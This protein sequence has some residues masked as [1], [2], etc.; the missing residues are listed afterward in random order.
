MRKFVLLVVLLAALA[1]LVACNQQPNPPAPQ[2]EAA[3]V[4]CPECPTC[5]EAPACPEVQ[6]CPEPE[7]CPEPVVAVVPFEEQ[8][9]GSPHNDAE[10]EAFV[11]WNEDD[12]A[13]I[14]EN[15]AKCHSTPG[16]IDFLGADGSDPNMVN[17]PAPI[18]STVECEAC[19]NDVTIHKTS[20]VFPS[21]IEIT[22]LGDESRCMECHQGRES[23]TSVDASI[24]AAGL[25]DE[26][27][28]VNADLGF[29]NIHYYAAAATQY[30]TLAKGG[31]EYDGLTYDAK[32]HHVDGFNTCN[33]CHDP[34]TLELNLEQCQ[35]CH[36]DVASPED[37]KAVRLEGSEADY[38]GDG[39]VEE[40]VM[41]EI[42]GLQEPLYQAIRAYASEVAGAPIVYDAAAHPYFFADGNDN[43]AVDEGEERYATWTPRL[44]RAAYNFQVSNKDP[45]EF[46]HNGKYIIQLLYDS[47]ADLN[48]SIAEPVDMTT[49][50]RIDP[51]HFAG[52][53][54]AFRHWDADGAVPGDCAKCHSGDG[55][56]QF[57]AE[58]TNTSQPP[59]NGFKCTTCHTNYE[60]YARIQIETVTFP[61]GAELTMADLDSNLCISCHQGRAW[62]GTIDAATG[63]LAEDTVP[64]NALRFT[65][66]HYFAAGATL[67]G[68][69]AKGAY[70]YPDLT[71]LGKFNH[72][73]GF[74]NCT[75]C[76][77]T[78]EL[79]LKTETCFT[80]H[81]GLETPQ[82]IRGPNSTADYDGDGDVTEGLANEIATYGEK[83]YAAMQ[84][85]ATE[86][87]G[88]AI[89]YDG[90][91]YPYFFED[92]DG[93]GEL[94]GDE[95]GYTAW[96]PRLLKAAYNYQYLQK[97][98]GAFAHNGKY[99]IQFLYDNLASLGEQVEVDMAGMI[100]PETP[101]AE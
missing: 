88:K 60:D 100:R 9:A 43:G 2:P 95:A 97:D 47:I 94:N 67:F 21:G 98:P 40:G 20:V 8:W 101:P 56:P 31:Y 90:H 12:P 42:L 93:N 58:G 13:Q 74:Q 57:V 73:P 11:H 14:P 38:D 70:Q 78:H 44:L 64:E 27:D 22:N 15:C 7:A 96:T 19:H 59:A 68:T 54:E 52:S 81:A 63:G 33:T 75:E 71:Y 35:T 85:Y 25:M 89:V 36:T 50:H 72:V 79:E 48:G 37:F 55:L 76:H 91:R 77:L 82:D 4:E 34:H 45:G 92:T 3:Q 49:M 18:G 87:V 80:C 10:S 23:K 24:E 41:E 69:E 51:G 84:T 5:P 39:N 46:A 53:E 99:V 30:G 26:P 32:F 83:L 16:Y 86:V 62:S 65:N 1:L 61:S 66:I 17:A 6:A 29:R 28:T